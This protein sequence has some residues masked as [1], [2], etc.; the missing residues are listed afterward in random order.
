MMKN[1]THYISAALLIAFFA[2]Q[3]TFAP[4]AFAQGGDNNTPASQSGAASK[5]KSSLKVTF[6]E[7]KRKPSATAASVVMAN[8]QN[9]QKNADRKGKGKSVVALG[10]SVKPTR[11]AK[12]STSNAGGARQTR[13][14]GSGKTLTTMSSSARSGSLRPRTTPAYSNTQTARKSSKATTSRQSSGTGTS[15]PLSRNASPAR[16]SASQTAK[17][18]NIKNKRAEGTRRTVN[19]KVVKPSSSNTK[20]TRKKSS[21]RKVTIKE[22]KKPRKK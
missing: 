11:Q 9:E 13:S 18:A 1:R 12:P 5:T 10:S 22:P 4:K 19:P 8:R 6:A 14:S 3:V 15:Q 16:P 2:A 21:K 17:T 7:D 20:S